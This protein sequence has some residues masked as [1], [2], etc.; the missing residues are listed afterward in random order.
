MAACKQERG[1]Q[2][3]AGKSWLALAEQPRFHNYSQQEKKPDAVSA[4]KITS[5][6][7][8]AMGKGGKEL[9]PAD[10]CFGPG[11]IG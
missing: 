7:V 6:K 10:G 1:P 2:P 5:P 9:P 4:P 11:S 8:M 3:M